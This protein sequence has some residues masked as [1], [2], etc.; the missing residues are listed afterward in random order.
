MMQNL[1]NI[2]L[3]MIC[4]QTRLYTSMQIDH[5]EKFGRLGHCI[6][7]REKTIMLTVPTRYGTVL[8]ISSKTDSKELVRKISQLTGD[9]CFAQILN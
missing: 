7:E 9:S 2:D 5:D 8:V 3:D 4:M 1:E 6:I